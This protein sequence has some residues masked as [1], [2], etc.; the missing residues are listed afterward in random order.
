MATGGLDLCPVSIPGRGTKLLGG[1]L[2][3]E[4]RRED[5]EKVLLEGFFPVCDK[6]DFAKRDRR[7]GLSEVGLAYESDPAITRHLARF[8]GL[9]EG[10]HP[11]S[12]LFNGGVFKAT[13]LRQRVLDVL[14]GWLKADGAP[15]VRELPG[16]YLDLAVARGAAYY[17]QVRQGKGIRI[18]GGTSRSYYIA[19]EIPRPAIPGFEPPTKAVCVAPFGMEEGSSADI[20]GMEFQLALGEHVEFPFLS[21]TS[22]R[23][24]AAGVS[25]EDWEDEDEIERIATVTSLLKS[26]SGETRLIPVRLQSKVTEIGTLELWCLE[27]DGEGSWKLEFEVRSP[28]QQRA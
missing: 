17:G 22:R 27:R 16:G 6:S 19:V 13:A 5:V 12:I 4:L 2:Q 1:A 23:E 3:S 10:G 8:L 28:Q 21:S 15:E 24:D 11:T 9:H 25:V 20:A 7:M 14:N 18:R 26:E